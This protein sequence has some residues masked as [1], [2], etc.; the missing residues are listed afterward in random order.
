MP[1]KTYRS[2][3]PVTAL[4]G[5]GDKFQIKLKKLGISTLSDLLDHYPSRFLDLTTPS[6]VKGCPIKKIISLKLT[7]DPAKTFY[8]RTGKLITQTTGHDSS[9]SILLTWF[10][11]PYVKASL[12]SN[13]PCIVVGKV[14]FFAGKKTLVAPQ[15]QSLSGQKIHCQGFVPIYPQTQ[16]VSSKWLRTKIDLALRSTNL[17]DPLSP[18]TIKQ[19]DLLP[20]SDAYQQIHFPNNLEVQKQADKRL[21]FDQH[22]EICL[23]NL[24][25]QQNLPPSISLKTSPSTHS[26]GL[27]KL[28]FKLTSGQKK[29]VDDLYQDLTSKQ[30]THR[31]IQGDTG[32]G[33]TATLI[34]AANQCLSQK[35]SFALL[36]PTQ[37]LAEQHAQTFKKMSLFPQSIQLVT[38]QNKIKTTSK[39]TIFIGT[40]ALLNQLP[41]KLP[42]PLALI[43][44]DEQH[45]F[46]V[47]QRQTLIERNPSPHLVNLSATPIPRT[48][49]LGIFGEISIS[50]IKHKPKNRLPATTWLM[51]QKRLQKGYSWLQKQIDD[52]QKVFVVCPNIKKSSI[53]DS[54]E[55]LLPFYQKQ[56]SPSATVLSLHGQM[57]A[58]KK[59]SVIDEFNRAKKAV[60]VSTSLIEVGIDIPQ[61]NIIIIHSAERFGLAQLHQLR[62]RVGRGE[63]P[64]FCLLIPFKEDNT[65]KERL[66]LMTKHHSG[67][68][69]ARLDLQLRG[70]GELF[71]LKQHG[72]FKT[73]LHYFWNRHLYQ[74]A[75]SLAQKMI[76]S[77]ASEC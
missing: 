68:K 14:S 63:Q 21:A 50:T 57:K 65:E 2:E 26:Q 59:T 11:S 16:G 51:D 53:A 25:Y 41:D 22:L 29:A 70:A 37:I 19:Q 73:R 48:I 36:A 28:P 43:A 1:S 49:A 13:T 66:Q 64:S 38:G 24:R 39:P 69:L 44:I 10:N 46:G 40:H 77:S 32:S 7:L 52:N 30:A 74:Q 31:L 54:V 8:S 20:L 27:K 35:Y 60:L 23:N 6:Q 62:G 47:D 4:P 17:K 34:L 67:L 61:A 18:Q 12:K 58:E 9:G 15:I 45:K 42:A 72:H 3:D 55:T 33:K 71:G 56:F 75:K 5:V 76:A